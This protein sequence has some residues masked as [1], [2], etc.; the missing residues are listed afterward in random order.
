MLHDFD[1]S[2]ALS[3]EQEGAE[4]WPKV[5]RAAFPNL[6]S[7]VSV[8]QNGWAQRG[9]IDRV[10]TLNCGKTLNIDEKVRQKD[11]GDVLLEYWSV[12][13]DGKGVTRGWAAKDLACDY[14]AYAWIPTERCLLIPFQ[15]LRRAW[16]AHGREWVTLGLQETCGF[17][18]VD[19]QNNG[20]VTR[21]VCVPE[22]AFMDAIR[23]SML[24]RW[25]GVI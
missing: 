4:W 1:K 21:S 18:V 13:R 3:H 14:L 12:M 8:R 7:M 5:Y 9:G 11:Y 24:I 16:R 15:E 19:A 23:E 25:T 22:S 20:Y 2:L 6:L 17:C 10:L